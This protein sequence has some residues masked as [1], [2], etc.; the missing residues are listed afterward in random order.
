MDF[1]IPITEDKVDKLGGRYV[2]YHIFLD[3]FVLCKVRY[4][5]MHRWNEKLRRVFKDCIPRFPP[6]Y[7][8]AMTEKMADQRRHHLEQYLQKVADISSIVTSEIFG[9]FFRKMQQ[10]TFRITEVSAVLDVFLPDLQKIRADIQTSDTAQTLLETVANKIGLSRDL[11]RYFGLFLVQWKSLE[12]MSVLKK[13]APF[14]SPVLSLETLKEQQCTIMILKSYM[15][16]SLDKTVMQ[17]SCAL[18]LLC[19]QAVSHMRRGWSCP[20]EQ[21]HQTLNAL[22]ET[23]QKRE[24]LEAAWHLKYYGYIQ[25]DPCTCDYPEPDCPAVVRVGYEG[26][27]C[28]IKLPSNQIQEDHFEISRIK[29]WR[30]NMFS[31]S[32]ID[33]EVL[34]DLSFE[35]CFAN[36]SCKWITIHTKQAFLISMFMRQVLLEWPAKK[37]E[38]AIEITCHSEPEQLG[39][40]SKVIGSNGDV[41]EGI[42]DHDL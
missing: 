22:L 9:K 34:L 25:V 24:F 36:K 12:E 10:E 15:D 28:C 31:K 26:I 13:L 16:R 33:D 42:Q 17:N 41:F 32:S 38:N 14:E 39:V 21:Q 11:Q 29:C 6:K 35:Y 23:G 7:Y 20:T 27:S 19:T 5:D 37:C 30:V 8:L 40:R 18:N 1:N 3:G 4:S 2:V